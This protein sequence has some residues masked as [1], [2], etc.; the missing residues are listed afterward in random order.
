MA[1]YKK[2]IHEDSNISELNNDSGYL[3]SVATS[4]IASS[5]VTNAKLGNA[6]V[7]EA[8]LGVNSVTSAKIA[9]GAVDIDAIG[10]NAVHTDEL[11]AAAVTTA[12]IADSA[13][14]GAKLATG[15]IDHPSKFATGVVSATAIDSSAV[16]A[17]ELNVVGN[18]TN[19]QFLRSDGDGTMTWATPSYTVNTDTNT[20]YSLELTENN[21]DVTIGLNPSSGSTEYWNLTSD[22]TIGMS[23]NE[24]TRETSFD[25]ADG[26]VG[27]TQL[28]NGS[29]TNDKIAN[30][31]VDRFKIASAGI[32]SANIDDNAVTPAKANLGWHTQTKIFVSPEEFSPN[33]HQNYGNVAMHS[34]GGSARMTYTA[35]EGY[36]NVMIPSGYKVTHFRINGTASVSISAHSSTCA[37]SSETS[38]SPPTSLSTNTTYQTNPTTGITADDTNGKY[39]IL[40]WLPTTTTQ[41]LYGAILTIAKI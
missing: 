28:E 18:G 27:T 10:A 21:P 32:R 35:I 31:A 26:G 25:I 8:K 34:N 4:N 1:T 15:A 13:V 38:V 11:K 16:G 3:T 24:S 37:T 22:G 5:A 33:D 30:G 20:T 17:S 12:K 2:V 19:S 23:T 41:Y 39:F 9:A 40:G 36:A 14:T 6:S 7:S 29:V